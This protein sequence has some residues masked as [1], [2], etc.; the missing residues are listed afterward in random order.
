MVEAID[1]VQSAV[2]IEMHAVRLVERDVARIAERRRLGVGA[3]DGNALL[4]VA[5][6]EADDAALHID[7]AD[8]AIIQ[9]R[10]V[11]LAAIGVERDAVDTA[12][13]GVDRGPVVAGMALLAR[14]GE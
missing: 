2:A 4:A 8:T 5:R 7:D 14:T 6:H 1:D 3:V 10:D 13:L 11:E 9:V 12:E